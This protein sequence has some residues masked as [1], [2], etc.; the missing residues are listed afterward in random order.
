MTEELPK[1]I[2]NTQGQVEW[3]KEIKYPRQ[4]EG[5]EVLLQD[6]YYSRGGKR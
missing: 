4:M 1:D 2:K 5:M 6:R 3:M